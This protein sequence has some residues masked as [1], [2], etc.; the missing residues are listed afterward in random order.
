MR[1]R[2][3][4]LTL[5]MFILAACEPAAPPEEFSA[6][7]GSDGDEISVDGASVDGDTLTVAVGHGG[8]CETH[9]YSICWPDQSFMESDPVQVNLEIFHDA[10]GDGCEAYLTSELQFDLT[11]LKTAWQDAYQ[12]SAGT[13][14]LHVDGQTVD[15]TF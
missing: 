7:E 15:Y 14:T 10:H 1:S 13:I 4:V 3:G 8:G 12:Q 9:T 11:P 5:S 2:C 6:C